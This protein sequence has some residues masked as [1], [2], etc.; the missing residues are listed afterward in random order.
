[1]KDIARLADPAARRMLAVVMALLLTFLSAEAALA[2][3]EF[4]GSDPAAD[5]V[6]DRLPGSI[7][8]RFSEQVGVLTL[9]WLL[10]GGAEAAARAEAGADSL[11]IDPPPEAGRGTYVLR[12]RVAS[13]DGHPVAGALVFSVGDISGTAPVGP[14][15]GTSALTAV[16]L[17]AAMVL[18]LVLSVGA[19]V[20]QALVAPLSRPAARAF[21]LCAGLVPPLG[22]LWLGAEGLDRLGLAFADLLTPPVR[23]EALHAPALFSVVLAAAS[24][25]LAVVA[26][27]AGRRGAALLAWALAA[28]SFAAS[29]HALS[30][31][32]RLALPLTVLHGG[33]LLFW[34]GS[35]LPL[36]L[37]LVPLTPAGRAGLLREY[38]RPA[39]LAV[40]VLI[41]TGAGLILIRPVGAET[42]ATPWARLLGAKLALVAVMLALALWHRARAVPQ[43]ARG[44]AA[45]VG[46]TIRIE[47]ALGLV[48]LCLAMGFRLAPPPVAPVADPPSLHLHG[49]K[50]MADIAFSASPP[51]A[52]SLRLS[53]ADGDFGPLEPQE[54]R[55]S[56]T[57]PEAGIGPLTVQALR[58]EPGLWI[59]P[60]VTLPSPGP[61]QVRL[62]LL[63][64]DFE[65]VTLTGDL[66]P[67]GRDAP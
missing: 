14:A 32:T 17:R 65:Q 6:L 19:A 58:Q 48:V 11:T 24:A 4:R 23:A 7:T 51:G 43:L 46:R 55:L 35:L 25:L 57:D 28:L 16:A 40:A 31:P 29:G 10:P 47:A 54:V 42:L 3:A 30:A 53:L 1:M 64:S 13:T 50:A 52:V 66:K 44:Q 15:T 9:S 21:A 2:H 27:L 60:P 26:L 38:S 49:P 41:G 37:S 36:A 20:F 56:L 12:W 5:A 63:V 61:W 45:P 22:L 59:T 39:L 8:L 34:V 18:A 62:M 33:A 67:F